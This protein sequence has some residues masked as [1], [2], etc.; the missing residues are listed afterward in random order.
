MKDGNKTKKQII[1]ELVELR[2]RITELDKSEAERKMMEEEL[3]KHREHLE[4]EVE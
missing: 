2:Q 1:N 3:K 4:R